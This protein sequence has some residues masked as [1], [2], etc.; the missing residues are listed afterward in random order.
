MDR[1]RDMSEK[2][3]L[4]RRDFLKIT[5]VMSV[6]S[7]LPDTPLKKDLLCPSRARRAQE[8]MD[9]ESLKTVFTTCL[10]CNARC[11]LRCLVSKGRIKEVSGNPYHPYNTLGSPLPY[12]TPVEE[13]KN[14]KA[15]TCGKA[16]EMDGYCHNSRRLLVPLKRAGRRGE[17][18]FEP[19]SW[20][21]LIDEIAFG[22]KLF[23][24][25]GEEREVPGLR[26]MLSD[27]PIDKAAPELGPVRNRFC[28][29]TGRLQSGRKEF[30][31]RFVKSSFGSI[32]RIGHTDICGLGFRMGN[33]AFTQGKEV[34]LK[35]DPWNA[36][37]ILVFGANIYEALQPGLNTYGATVA[38]RHSEGELKFVIVDP[39][40]QKAGVQAHRW[41]KIMPGQD[42]AFALGMIRWM[43]ENRRFSREYLEAPNPGAAHR[44]GNGGYVNAAH[45]VVWQP[46]HP[47]H[48]TFL[49][50]SD[51]CAVIEKGTGKPCACSKAE[52]GELFVDRQIK[53]DGGSVRVK[54]AFQLVKEEAFRYSLEEYA[55]FCGVEEADICDVAREFAEHAPFSATC[56]YHGAGNYVNGTY[57]AYAVAMLNA[58]SGS[59]GRR[60]GYLS[61]AKGAGAWHEGR[62][63]LKDFRGKKRPSGV[64]ISRE[65]A[66]YRQSS[67][68]RRRVSKGENPYPAKRPWF[69]FTKGG[70]CVEA[71]SGIDE[72]YPYSIDALFLYFFNPV[73]SIPGGE[74]FASTL[75]DTEKV[76]LLVSIDIGINESN[77][78]ADYIVPDITYAE[79]QY[80]WLSPHAPAFRFTSFR[81]PV[82]EPVTDKL[83]DGRPVCLETFLIDLAKRLDLPGFGKDVIACQS[84][85]GRKGER[86]VDLNQAEDFYLRAYFNICKNAGLKSIDGRSAEFVEKNYPVARYRGILEADEWRKLCHAL[87]RGGIFYPYDDSFD[88]ERF[89]HGPKE[90]FVYSEALSKHVCSI[91]GKPFFGGVRY[92]PPI[93]RQD[94]DYPLVL[95]SYKD[96]LHTQSRTVWHDIALEIQPENFIFVNPSDAALL[97]LKDMDLVIASS[98]WAGRQVAGRLKVWEGVRPGVAAISISYGHR[99]LGASRAFIKDGENAVYGKERVCENGVIVAD[100]RLGAGV[101]PNELSALDARFSDTPLV[102]LIGGIPDFSSTCITLRKEQD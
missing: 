14:I 85:D 15:T 24:H 91:T 5:G 92:V 89:L 59:I 83:S 33:F 76:P 43:I 100:R 26:S 46:G 1:S 98:R 65:K 58:L 50:I 16:Q 37:Y 47:L 29:L 94:D 72:G 7:S 102:D 12:D 2:T 45:L 66:D 13:V 41:I 52:R 4:S 78:Y 42:G 34:E 19:I 79:G 70:L 60:G 73:Y 38:R 74:R 11:G 31:D 87:A 95:V 49:K 71:L 56:Q 20:Q 63:D 55:G 82:I 39:R 99:A 96:A 97:R 28:F 77:I 6:A 54:S 23:G 44:L 88:R 90:F 40:A 8:Y 101:N 93:Y 3:P 9:D 67:F 62:Y 35:A 18:K 22:G 30:I 36:K 27:E 21:R 69:P 86:Y 17:G 10:G 80:G 48:G 25:L 84:E 53:I 75:G 64:R 68:Y 51:E 32:N 61:S 81:V 57:A